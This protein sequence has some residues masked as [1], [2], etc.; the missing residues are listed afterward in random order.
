MASN[1]ENKMGTNAV[2]HEMIEYI[3]T[4]ERVLGDP[5]N[6]AGSVAGKVNVV[7]QNLIDN[8]NYLKEH[9]IS[10]ADVNA[11]I[12]AAVVAAN[13][14]TAGIAEVA[15]QNETNTGTDDTKIVTPQKLKG[16]SFLQNIIPTTTT[17]TFTKH[18]G[19]GGITTEDKIIIGKLLFARISFSSDTNTNTVFRITGGR[20]RILSHSHYNSDGDWVTNE[21]VFSDIDYQTNYTE[22]QTNRPME[23]N[24]ELNIVALLIS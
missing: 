7:F 10:E 15:T 1:F 8:I 12:A 11:L 19:N 4:S 9:G 14:N 23:T 5:A 18:S 22:F 24:D 13:E 3:L 6:L 17:A 20:W 21:P 2:F 16:A